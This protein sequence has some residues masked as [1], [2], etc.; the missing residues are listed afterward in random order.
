MKFIGY[1]Q[2]AGGIIGLIFV[3]WGLMYADI[4]TVSMILFVFL[5]SFY[6]YSIYCGFA[7]LER[8]KNSFLHTTIN[9]SL[10]IVAFAYGGYTFEYVAGVLFVID[11]YSNFPEINF[12]LGLSRFNLSINAD[13]SRHALQINLMPVAM[14]LYLLNIKRAMEREKFDI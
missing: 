10:Q 7:L 9:Q 1:Y 8:K 14:L 13:Y 11:F 2:F 12:K 3:I 4:T 6:I 5:M